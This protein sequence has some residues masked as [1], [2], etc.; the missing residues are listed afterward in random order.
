MALS[1]ALG[2]I[3]SV[4]RRRPPIA[5]GVHAALVAQNRLHG[6][7][8]RRDA[9][10]D[11]I[12]GGA[13]VV[14]TGQQLGVALGPLYTLWKAASAVRIARAL[15]DAGTP[16]VPLFWLHSEDHDWD[17]IRTLRWPFEGEIRE[18]SLPPRPAERARSS[19]AHERVGAAIEPLID[20]IR[21]DV[22]GSTEGR[23]LVDRLAAHYR[24]EATHVEAFGGWLA[25]L[26]E[27]YG[28][29]TFHPRDAAIAPIAAA[30]HRRVIE[31]HALIAPRLAERTREIEEAGGR[32]PIPIRSDCALSF[33]HPEGPE[34]ARY[35]LVP[36]GESFAL[37]GAPDEL[38]RSALLAHI[39]RDPLV[40][41]TSALLRPVVQDAL[42]PT[43]AYVGGPSEVAYAAQLAPIYAH[44][45]IEMA[46]FVRRASFVAIGPR[47][48]SDLEAL[49]LSREELC[50]DE[51]E[52]VQRLGRGPLGDRIDA[53]ARTARE[54]LAD[55]RADLEA[56]DPGLRKSGRKSEAQIDDTLA[57][58]RAR[59][60]RASAARRPDRIAALR[61]ARAVLRPGGEPQERVHGVPAI[62]AHGVARLLEEAIA[63]AAESEAG[64]E[65]ELAP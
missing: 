20:A 2:A 13:A 23:A 37:S 4:A 39:E 55:L 48:R 9:S 3:A 57:K 62:A 51:A 26:F 34:G 12:A 25:E 27:P 52:L 58:L 41:S 19:I 45:G 35:R 14:V 5:P 24:P 50:E 65:V 44:V 40:L 61:R 18:A 64:S 11:A 22:G 1:E 63:R 15:T 53:I 29:V 42:L 47:E 30:V 54:A 36:R 46:P 33:F 60:E 6:P 28:L 56:L 59:V 8:A 38:S 10:L 16:A 43:A 7:S 17:E 31:G 49:G 32:A 21:R